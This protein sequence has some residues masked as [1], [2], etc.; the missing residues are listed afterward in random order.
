MPPLY[1]QKQAIKY[2][3]NTYL[4]SD[5]TLNEIIITPGTNDNL[6]FFYKEMHY[7]GNSLKPNAIFVMA[8]D[9]LDST[10]FSLN[11]SYYTYGKQELEIYHSFHYFGEN[12]FQ[13]A[14]DLLIEN[15]SIIIRSHIEVGIEDKPGINLYQLPLHAVDHYKRLALHLLNNIDSLEF[16]QKIRPFDQYDSLIGK[17]YLKSHE[18]EDSTFTYQITERYSDNILTIDSVLIYKSA[19]PIIKNYT[20]NH[21]VKSANKKR[22]HRQIKSSP[23]YYLNSK[24]TKRI[25]KGHNYEKRL[26]KHNSFSYYEIYYE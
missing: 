6:P 23:P 9:T 7:D 26:D 19:C 3:K 22:T 8:N 24:S 4:N 14:I 5:S 17:Q 15:D 16:M 13:E 11:L 25:A 10:Y 1:G 12:P 21:Q 20:L 18:T 2:V